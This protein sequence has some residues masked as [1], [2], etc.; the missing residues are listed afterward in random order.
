MFTSSTRFIVIW[1]NDVRSSTYPCCTT[2]Q[3]GSLTPRLVLVK[4]GRA[5]G[6]PRYSLPATCRWSF[7][8][9]SRL[10]D[11]ILPDGAFTKRLDAERTSWAGDR[12]TMG[13][14]VI[15]EIAGRAHCLYIHSIWPS[16]PKHQDER[17]VCKADHRHFGLAGMFN[18]WFVPWPDYPQRMNYLKPTVKWEAKEAGFFT[19]QNYRTSGSNV[20]FGLIGLNCV[21][22]LNFKSSIFN[23]AGRII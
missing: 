16:I 17:N 10:T 18:H 8:H 19:C 7:F 23:D 5:N 15:N 14:R 12:F 20:K 9:S 22:W 11:E 21:V 1:I 3:A 4:H 2:L 6:A 13:S